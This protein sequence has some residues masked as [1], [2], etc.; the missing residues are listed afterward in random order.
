MENIDITQALLELKNL[1]VSYPHSA[2]EESEAERWK[3]TRP[4]K[5]DRAMFCMFPQPP[6][7][8][9]EVRVRQ[10]ATQIL[11]LVLPGESH[12]FSC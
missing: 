9:L 6:T 12:C 3:G 5:R 8:S 11:I 10:A 2:D 4:G 7:V 1:L